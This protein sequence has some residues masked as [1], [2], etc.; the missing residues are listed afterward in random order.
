MSGRLHSDGH[1]TNILSSRYRD[2]GLGLRKGT[3]NGYSGA[4]VWTAH[5]GYRC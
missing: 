1:R 5:F 3:L 2:L 4:H